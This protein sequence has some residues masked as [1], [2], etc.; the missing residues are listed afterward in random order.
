MY[1]FGYVHNSY[2]HPTNTLANTFLYGYGA[3]L[4]LLTYY[5]IVLNVSYAFNRMGEGGFFF[6]IKAPIF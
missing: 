5:D 6:G 1:D 3:G 4:D 2:A